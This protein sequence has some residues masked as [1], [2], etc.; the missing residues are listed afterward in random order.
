MPLPDAADTKTYAI[1]PVPK[2]RQTQRDSWRLRPPVARYRAFRD[3][4]RLHGVTLPEF[5]YH[6]I[7]V[8]P[9][10]A[11]WPEA[12]K[13]AMDGQPHQRR[14]DKDNLEKALLD[15][16]YGEDCCVWDGRVTKLWGRE[17]AIVIRTAETAP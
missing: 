15:A 11:S 7:F 6:V 13:R 12:K 17:G 2:P 5:G 9:M 8:L 14:P 16:V 4:V 3:E 1:T 10:P